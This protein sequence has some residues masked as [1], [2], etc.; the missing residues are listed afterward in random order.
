MNVDTLLS[1]VTATGAGGELALNGAR[2]CVLQA[3][4][5]T[6]AGSGSAQVLVQG[7][8]DGTNWET[9]GTITL[10]LDTTT[11]SDSFVIDAPWGAVRGYVSSISGTGATVSLT[12]G[13]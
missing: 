10:T 3:S 7:T 13:H 6:T 4:G 2:P 8:N 9:I 5:Y 1:N 11:T 12:M